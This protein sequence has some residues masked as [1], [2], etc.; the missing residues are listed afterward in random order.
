MVLFVENNKMFGLLP[1]GSDLLCLNLDGDP[2]CKET[3]RFLMF[4]CFLF[5]FFLLSGFK[6]GFRHRSFWR[7]GQPKRGDG[8]D[9]HRGFGRPAGRARRGTLVVCIFSV[10]CEWVEQLCLFL[11]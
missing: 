9:V 5:H 7:K 8:R 11:L 4:E 1:R 2:P 3:C 6:N 10:F